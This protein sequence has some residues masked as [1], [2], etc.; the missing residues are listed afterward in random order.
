M[1]AITWK[2]TLL[3]VF[4]FTGINLVHGTSNGPKVI[5]ILG[6]DRQNGLVYLTYTW[7]A[8]CDCETDLYIY[9]LSDGS[10]E[11]NKNWAKRRDYRLK[12]D[13]V[14]KSKGLDF[15]QPI[16][17]IEQAIPEYSFMWLP[18]VAYYSPVIMK[19]TVNC[20]FQITL[21]DTNFSYTQCYSRESK[22]VV[23]FLEI[24]PKIGLVHIR[25]KGECMEGNTV[26]EA[27]IYQHVDEK[28]LCDEV[29]RIK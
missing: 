9:K 14:I 19:D 25:Y 27:I 16:D 17:T 13:E 6:V 20:P 2:N 29:I 3:T 12:R 15:L 10:I 8:E 28:L 22:P 11:I 18:K 24:A 23:T 4:I 7:W 1:R 5:D 21:G 26:D